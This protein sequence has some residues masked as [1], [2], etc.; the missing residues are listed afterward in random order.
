ML[1]RGWVV[2]RDP[3]ASGGNSLERRKP[4]RASASGSAKPRP[5]GTASRREQH[6]V[7]GFPCSFFASSFWNQPRTIQPGWR[8]SSPHL[9]PCPASVGRGSDLAATSDPV[10]PAVLLRK[11]LRP[12]AA[13]P[14]LDTE[15]HRVAARPPVPPH[16]GSHDAPRRV[17]P[18]Q[19]LWR[20]SGA[21]PGNRSRSPGH[22]ATRAVPSSDDTKSTA[23]VVAPRSSLAPASHGRPQGRPRCWSLRAPSSPSGADT[24]M[25]R[26]PVEDVCRAEIVTPRGYPTPKGA[27]ISGRINALEGA[28]PRAPPA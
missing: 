21:R 13:K 27:R 20:P 24:R 22:V 8:W 25:V 16:V 11:K 1:A 12:R 17:A 18:P 28:T 26:A 3:T 10:A 4:R 19:A 6:P 23:S 2:Q 14:G 9:D 5:A 15:L 7:D